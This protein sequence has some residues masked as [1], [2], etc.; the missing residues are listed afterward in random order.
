MAK[1][2]PPVIPKINFPVPAGAT[3]TEF[4]TA[5][6]LLQSLD[7]EASGLYLVGGNGERQDGYDKKIKDAYDLLK[8]QW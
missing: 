3:G 5:G 8:G 6:D 7:R 1:R 2:T 4:S